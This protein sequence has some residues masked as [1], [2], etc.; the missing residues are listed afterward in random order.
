[1]KIVMFTG[2]LGSGKTTLALDFARHL[3]EEGKKT[4]FIINEAGEIALDSQLA[5]EKNYRV[6]EVFAGC[7]CCQVSDDFIRALQNI[8]KDE[9]PDRIIIEPTGVADPSS[10]INLLARE[11]FLKIPVINVVDIP[12][13]KLLYQAIPLIENG[14][15][16]AN[17][18][19]INKLD[20]MESPDELEYAISSISSE[21][22]DARIFTVSYKKGIPDS[23]WKEVA[24]W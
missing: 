10:M 20:Q 2:F 8:I 1:M 24:S 3:S 9:N 21:N 7:I 6:E 5:R 14:L 15:R 17:A 18:V 13:F 22:K 16:S 11:G 4:A 19:I 23:V 12:R